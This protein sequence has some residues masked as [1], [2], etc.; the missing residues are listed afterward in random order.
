MNTQRHLTA[1]VYKQYHPKQQKS[2]WKLYYG[3]NKTAWFGPAIYA[4]CMAEKKRLMQSGQVYKEQ[5][6]KIK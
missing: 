3:D 4:H 5:L 6:F 2:D 1:I